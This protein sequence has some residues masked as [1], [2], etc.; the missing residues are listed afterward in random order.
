MCEEGVVVYFQ[1]SAAAAPCPFD[2]KL[3]WKRLQRQETVRG[4]VCKIIV[5]VSHARYMICNP[6]IIIIARSTTHALSKHTTSAKSERLEQAQLQAQ[7]CRRKDEA[8][9]W[10]LVDAAIG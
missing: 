9:R 2:S 4:K 5:M 1:S 3:G 10:K 6:C 7:C 8:Y